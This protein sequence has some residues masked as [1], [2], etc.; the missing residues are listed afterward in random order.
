MTV[1]ALVF[2]IRAR[3][4]SLY[5]HLTRV[6]IYAVDI[7]T[8]LGLGGFELESLRTAALLHDI[9]K[10]A[11]PDHILSKPGKLT[12]AEFEQMKTHAV[13]GA[14]ILKRMQL[15][16]LVAQIVL[17]HHEKW[18][19]KGYPYGLKGR[20]IPRSARVLSAV[21]CLDALSSDRQYRRAL[22]LDQAM[23]IVA[24]ESGQSYDPDVIAILQ[25]RY[26]TKP[27]RLGHAV[28]K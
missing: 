11:I 1:E 15:P 12:L 22:P 10:L 19:G 23:A 9:G 13:I 14:E 21:D 27:L 8:E 28:G 4:P 18:N 20:E 5:G 26:K 16:Y 6:Q 3:D 2:A 24:S 7:G 17:T 25:S